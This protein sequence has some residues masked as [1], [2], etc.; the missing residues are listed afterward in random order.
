MGTFAKGRADRQQL[1][2]LAAVT[3]GY[4][5]FPTDMEKRRDTMAEIVREVS[6][7]YTIGYY[8]ANGTYD[9]KWRKIRI[10]VTDSGPSGMKH[11]ARTRSGYY[12]MG[13]DK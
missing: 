10:A 8:P 1:E 11:V 12:A 9:G 5:H 7:H 2:E 6:E 4:A 3:G 13:T